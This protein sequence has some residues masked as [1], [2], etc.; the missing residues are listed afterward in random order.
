MPDKSKPRKTT[1]TTTLMTATAS[2]PMPAEPDFESEDCV[3]TNVTVLVGDVRDVGEAA[4]KIVGTATFTER[5]VAA[6]VI[7]TA[8]EPFSPQI[9]QSGTPRK[10]TNQVATAD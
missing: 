10:S 4:P 6:L 5:V 8:N 9:P 7:C 3:T 2:A 1:E